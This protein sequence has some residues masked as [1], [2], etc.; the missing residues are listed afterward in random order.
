MSAANTGFPS[1]PIVDPATGELTTAWRM[2]LL[3]MWSRTGAAVGVTPTPGG[4]ASP[5]ALAAETAARAA[6]DAAV[7]T[8]VSANAAAIGVEAAARATHDAALATSIAAEAAARTH[9]DTVEV[10]AR[11]AAIAT[12]RTGRVAVDTALALVRP[13]VL[14]VTGAVP[15]DIVC[16]ADGEPVYVKV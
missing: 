12:E 8:L 16:T 11:N 3:A 14:L 10:T 5:A 6:G 7:G 4:G 1:A 13:L 15:V 9:A 2:F